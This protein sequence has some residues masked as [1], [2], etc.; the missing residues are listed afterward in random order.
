MCLATTAYTTC[1][2]HV[3]TGGKF[4]PVSNLYELRPLP[5]AT[6]S[7]VHLLVVI[8]I[9]ICC[10]QSVVYQALKSHSSLS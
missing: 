4:Q 5:L 3:T 8:F 6:R 7:Y 1:T 9:P 2:V 10:S